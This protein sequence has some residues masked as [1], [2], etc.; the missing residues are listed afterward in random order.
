MKSG[1]RRPR[2]LDKRDWPKRQIRPKTGRTQVIPESTTLPTTKATR[3][4]DGMEGSTKDAWTG[5]IG[6]C[7]G[8]VGG[9][10]NT[11]VIGDRDHSWS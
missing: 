10:G 8:V 9:E 7:A 1:R 11:W 5:I 3:E 2:L 6:S 4:G